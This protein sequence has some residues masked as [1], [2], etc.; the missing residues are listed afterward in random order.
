MHLCPIF[1][2]FVLITFQSKRIRVILFLA[3]ATSSSE[4]PTFLL[5]DTWMT[6]WFLVRLRKILASCRKFQVIYFIFTYAK[7]L[8]VEVMYPKLSALEVQATS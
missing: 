4:Y 2:M 7:T 1:Q 5:I 3:S 8:P 6:M